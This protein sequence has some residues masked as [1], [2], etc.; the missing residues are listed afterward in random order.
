MDRKRNVLIDHRQPDSQCHLLYF[1]WLVVVQ[2][3][4]GNFVEEAETL[5]EAFKCCLK[6]FVASV[7]APYIDLSIK[8]TFLQAFGLWSDP[9]SLSPPEVLTEKMLNSV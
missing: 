1:G 8:D 5:I 6:H 3:P 7:A 4:P 9:E 2:W